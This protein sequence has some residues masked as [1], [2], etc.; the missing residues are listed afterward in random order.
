MAIINATAISGLLKTQYVGPINS[1]IE[2][3]VML[4]KQLS[5]TNRHRIGSSKDIKHPVHL[6]K[7]TS[8]GFRNTSSDGLPE[9]AGATVV[10]ASSAIKIM[11]AYI[12]LYGDTLRLTAENLG[13]FAEEFKFEIGSLVDSMKTEINRALYG[14]GTGELGE[15][16]AGASLAS[17]IFEVRT[18]STIAQTPCQYW[19]EKGQYVDFY[20]PTGFATTSGGAFVGGATKLNGSNK[21]YIYNK[22][23]NPTTGVLQ[24]TIYDSAT[25]AAADLSG[26]SV[27][28]RALADGDKIVP[29]GNYVKEPF[30]LKAIIDNGTAFGTFL[31]ISEAVYDR[32]NAYMEDALNATV[33]G[34]FTESQMQNVID[35]LEIYDPTKQ[36][37]LLI[38]DK[39]IRNKIALTVKSTMIEPQTLELKGGFKAISYGGTPIYADIMAPYGKLWGC[40]LTNIIPHQLSMS[41]DNIFNGFSF[42][43]MD[44]QVLHATRGG[45]IYWAKGVVNYNITCNQRNSHS[46][47]YN[48]NPSL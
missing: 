37:I 5:W 38:T 15:V 23:F 35:K 8:I 16:E 27:L 25:G 7:N 10:Q 46:L 39:L 36:N 22:T 42:D 34:Q 11:F 18:S 33:P 48:I 44:G 29:A 24:L 1:A 3:E 40:N 41:K 14:D 30:G 31:G 21:L 19:F 13:A 45:D 47:Y 2:K 26:T 12:E 20:D 28:T 17:G 6:V 32:W 9:V 4:L 43:D